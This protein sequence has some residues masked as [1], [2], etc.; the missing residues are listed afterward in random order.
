M[1][2]DGQAC[3]LWPVMEQQM[4]SLVP[5]YPSVVTL[6]LWGHMVMMIRVV[7][8]V[9][10]MCLSAVAA[11]QA[12]GCDGAALNYFWSSLSISGDIAVVRAHGDD[13]MGGDSVSEYVYQG[14]G[15]NWVFY[16]SFQCF[17]VFYYFLSSN[18]YS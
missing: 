16:K 11:C 9:Q 5:V 10:H 1:D 8:V 18:F 14:L 12:C 15:V 13:D 17:N 7:L 2:P 6:Q 3:G 4:T